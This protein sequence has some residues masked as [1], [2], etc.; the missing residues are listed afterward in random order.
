VL[1]LGKA[2]TPHSVVL[3]SYE[4]S[5]DRTVLAVRIADLAD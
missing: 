2:A 3:F 5:M 4:K 1:A